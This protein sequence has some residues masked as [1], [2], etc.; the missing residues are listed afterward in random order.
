VEGSSDAG[1]PGP[2]EQDAD[3]VA[4]AGEDGEKHRVCSEAMGAI[5]GV[6]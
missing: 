2:D 6:Y 5:C 3:E 1:D 4:H